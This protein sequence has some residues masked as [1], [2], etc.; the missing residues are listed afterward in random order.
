M[1]IRHEVRPGDSVISL[2]E[3]YGHFAVTIWDDPANSALKAERDNMNALLPGDV[4][5][6]PDK[7][8]KTVDKPATQ[9]HRF[10]RKGIPAQLRLQVFD[11]ETP[12]ASQD[13]T[14]VVDGT[15]IKGTTDAKGTLEEWISPTA[16]RGKLT[17]GPDQYVI[18]LAFGHLGPSD[19]L[20]GVQGRLNNL[21][22]DCGDAAGEMNAQTQAAIASFRRRFG[23]NPSLD[24][25]QEFMDALKEQHDEASA[26]PAPEQ[27]GAA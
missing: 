5:V 3:R 8:P 13:Y 24:V 23:L 7:R 12:R 16:R 9:R 21:G 11:I 15:I 10:R 2:S 17:I 22:F 14:L 25:D 18:E 6:I 26:F 4:V 27:Q 1:P 19:D 20:A